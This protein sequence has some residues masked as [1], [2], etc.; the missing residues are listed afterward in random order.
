MSAGV[1]LDQHATDHDM[2]RLLDR[3]AALSWPSEKTEVVAGWPCRRSVRTSSRRA[4]SVLAANGTEQTGDMNQ[5][6]REVEEWYERLGGRSRFQVSPAAVPGNLDQ[7]LAARG[8]KAEALTNVLS[9]SRDA[10]AT[11]MMH[12]IDVT[13]VPDTA[14]R[15]CFEQA[16]PM[17]GEA[18]GRIRTVDLAR[19]RGCR[20]FY[21]SGVNDAGSTIAIGAAIVVPFD[22]REYPVIHN[23]NTLHGERGRGFGGAVLQALLQ[24]VLAIG[25]EAV[26]LLVEAD[27]DAALRLYERHGF[28]T[29][30]SYHYRTLI[31]A[32]KVG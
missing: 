22:G 23:M 20:T 4:N 9:V 10:F 11:E 21:A 8:Y 28:E 26:Y 16:N 30:Y 32:P 17:P 25:A 14:W 7:M 31:P 13:E 1:S 2:I 19:T 5:R 18:D 24:S 6:L 12:T 29:L 15:R 3:V 27:N